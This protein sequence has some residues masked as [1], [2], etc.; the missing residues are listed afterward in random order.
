MQTEKI[1]S[2]NSRGFH[3]LAVSV[4]GADQTPDRPV[5]CVH[6]LTRNRH[7]FDEL[8]ESL[9]K[10][11][12]V[13][14]VDMPGRG[15]SDCL[16]D[17]MDYSFSQYMT[18][19]LALLSWSHASQVD[20]IGTSMGGILGM[21]LSAREGSPIRR[22]LL[23]DVGPI[24]AKEMVAKLT[25]YLRMKRVRYASLHEVEVLLRKMNAGYGVLTDAQWARM[26]QTSARQ[27]ADG[28]YEL[29]YDP[30][31]ADPFVDD[32]EDVNLWDI[33][34]RVRCP[35]LVLRGSLSE[36]LPQN[37]AQEMTRRGPCARLVEIEGAGHAPSL[38]DEKQ[39]RIVEEFLES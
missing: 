18:D 5:I 29:I 26:A 20:W 12:T 37:I 14:C 25:E 27:L 16:P 8:A 3:R 11:R 38:M 30:H 22:L 35:T 32:P 15:D 13:Y 36:L 1:L 17:P 10:N 4:F 21:L 7:D 9:A 2:F 6:G 19:A 23:N 28:R 39:I 34:D 33:Y 24:V 31:I